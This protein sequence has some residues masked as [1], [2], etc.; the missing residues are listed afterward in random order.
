MPRQQ[1]G[2]TKMAALRDSAGQLS[3]ELINALESD[4]K[5]V[6]EVVRILLQDHFPESLQEDIVSAV[7]L[8]PPELQR[9]RPGYESAA[10]TRYGNMHESEP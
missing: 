5:A 3:E 10:L 1:G 4:Q 9:V 7:G 6:G 2:F 8:D